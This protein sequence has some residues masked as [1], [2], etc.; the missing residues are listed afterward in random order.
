MMIDL[1]KTH[2][3]DDIFFATIKID[4]LTKENLEIFDLTH[5]NEVHLF[6]SSFRKKL[7]GDT[8]K[9][10]EDQ[11]LSIKMRDQFKFKKV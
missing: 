9:E 2:E 11:F 8:I 1:G 3:N 4:Y 6:L 10:I 7:S 5:L